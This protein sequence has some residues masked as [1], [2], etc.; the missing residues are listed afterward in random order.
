[1][2]TVAPTCT[3]QGYTLYVCNTPGHKDYYRDYTPALGHNVE[4]WTDNGENHIGTC[5][6]CGETVTGEHNLSSDVIPAKCTE[7]GSSGNRCL[8][9]GH[10]ENVVIPALG[11]DYTSVVTAPTCTEAGHTTYTCSRCNDTYTEVSAPA[12]GHSF[13]PWTSVDSATHTHTCSRCGETVTAN[14]NFST[15]VTEATCTEEGR[16]STVCSDCGYTTTEPIPALGHN[17]VAVETA[18]TC[19]EA[20]YTTHTCSRCGDSYK[21]DGAPAT[22]HTFG[23]WTDNGE[24][25]I[26][27]CANCDATETA[28]HDYETS[29]TSPTCTEAGTI[30]R[31]CKVCGHV[32]KTDGDPAL[33]HD[34]TS[35]V[36]APTCTEADI[37]PSLAHAAANYKETGAPAYTPRNGA[38]ITGPPI[39]HMLKV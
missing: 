30:T 26:R 21:T 24:N 19:T 20:G 38:A 16:R 11:H 17:Y 8:I 31:T 6:R 35:V 27:H 9:C 3:E 13:G 32:E 10:G 39:P 28:A 4:S 1:M 29:T 36:T 37:P 23:T 18:P 25:H 14:H 33:G 22:G 7:P 12:L 2:T 5:T 15:V 34:Y